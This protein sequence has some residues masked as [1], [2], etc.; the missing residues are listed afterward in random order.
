MVQATTPGRPTST[1][2]RP[3]STPSRPASTAG[4]STPTASRPTS[5]DRA[6]TS[7][8]F[9]VV[10]GSRHA[11]KDPVDRV[12]ASVLADVRRLDP[13]RPSELADQMRLD[14]STVS[15]HI[16]SLVER[17][18][19]ERTADPEDARAQLVRLT[20]DG[21]GV[22]ATILDERATALGAAVRHW[23][24]SDRR[25]LIGLLERLAE[26]LTPAAPKT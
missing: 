2:G 16:T 22:L 5:T 20:P 11:L 18:L 10:Q 17:G 7:A 25:L 24:A 21:E 12:T 15:R 4:R 1:P 3:T 23:S 13:V 19:L 8:L 6:L 14:L 9:A 26:D